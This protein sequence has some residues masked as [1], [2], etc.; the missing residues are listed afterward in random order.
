[1]RERERERNIVDK[2]EEQTDREMRRIS[3]EMVFS[4]YIKR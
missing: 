2:E 1:L 3:R 4:I